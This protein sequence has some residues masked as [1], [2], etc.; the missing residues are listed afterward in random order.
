[1]QQLRDQGRDPFKEMQ[2]P[3]AAMA[4]KQGCGRLIRSERDR[5]LL[6]VGDV[7]L[8]DKAYGRSLL[9]SL[10]PFQRTRSPQQ[11]IAWCERS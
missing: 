11:A 2:L 7:R 4:L 10:P 6:M 8:A 9:K 1:M 5:G 3:Q